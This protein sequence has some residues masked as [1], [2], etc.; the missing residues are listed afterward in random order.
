MKPNPTIAITLVANLVLIINSAQAGVILVD[1]QNTTAAPA[2]GGT[3]NELEGVNSDLAPGNVVYEDGSIATGISITIDNFDYGITA[4][5]G[6][7]HSGT[8]FVDAA[9]ASQAWLKE[10]AGIATITIAGL[11][12]DFTY[13]ISLLAA[14]QST[15]VMASYTINGV[16][17]DE[18]NPFNLQTQ[19]WN[20]GDILDWTTTSPVGGEIIINAERVDFGFAYVNALRIESKAIP[21]PSTGILA[22]I[23]VIILM[24]ARHS[25]IRMRARTA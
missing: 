14:R 22:S 3:W 6:W 4:G 20:A 12:A 2:Q 10:D 7:A 23:G 11:S 19:G 24:L 5:T 15:N 16:A 17:S 8:T 13:D 25:R 21:E 1:F 9:A 18:D